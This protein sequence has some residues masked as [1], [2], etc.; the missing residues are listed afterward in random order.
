MKPTPGPW[1]IEE[2]SMGPLGLTI[3]AEDSRYVAFSEGYQGSVSNA[4][5][6]FAL[7]AAAPELLEALRAML[8]MATDNRTHGPEIDLACAAIAKAERRGSP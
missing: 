5:N 1:H 4:K 6:T 3:L 2:N 8:D 7:I